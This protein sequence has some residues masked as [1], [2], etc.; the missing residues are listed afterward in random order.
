MP[1]PMIIFVKCL[2]LLDLAAFYTAVIGRRVLGGNAFS[3]F[4]N[5]FL[6]IGKA[7]L[8]FGN[9]FFSCPFLGLFR[10]AAQDGLMIVNLWF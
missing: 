5:A 4:G 8:K 6:K 2:R 10:A 7:F 1:L 9:A 3:N